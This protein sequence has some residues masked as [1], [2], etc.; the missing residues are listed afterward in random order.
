MS[1]LQRKIVAL[2]NAEFTPIPE[3]EASD[4]PRNSPAD[5]LTNC[6]GEHRAE[7]APSLV[8]TVGLADVCGQE[9]SA[10]NTERIS[11]CIGKNAATIES[12][13]ECLSP[14]V[15]SSE[16]EGRTSHEKSAL[17]PLS[18]TPALATEDD[19]ES[20]E[21]YMAKLMQRVRGDGPQVAASQAA[22]SHA[23][24]TAGTQST[25]AAN[26]SLPQAMQVNKV[27][28]G[29]IAI[30]VPTP[31]LKDLMRKGPILESSIDLEAFRSLANESARR[32]IGVH[33]N[34]KHRRD[35]VTKAIFSTI[36]GMIGLRL[37]LH[38]SDWRDLLFLS[39]CVSLLIAAYCAGQAYRALTKAIRASDFERFDVEAENALEPFRT[40]LPID[41]EHKQ[42]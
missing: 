30:Q 9:Q 33:A 38:A 24:S 23:P 12:P 27:E 21:L 31:N 2:E 15:S 17:H 20:I 18:V 22:P 25:K 28:S 5:S 35:A 37:M 6:D 1:E 16:Y 29:Q 34:R 10:S 26:T 3:C 4:R 41:V 36:A 14:H 8:S 11:D 13:S 7:P 19:E 40:H 39:G 42:Q 32:A